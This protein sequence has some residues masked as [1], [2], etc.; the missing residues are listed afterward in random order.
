MQSLAKKH[1]PQT[2]NSS[3]SELQ[4]IFPEIKLSSSGNLEQDA[5]ESLVKLCKMFPLVSV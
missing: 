4:R 3:L 2:L 1:R 5:A